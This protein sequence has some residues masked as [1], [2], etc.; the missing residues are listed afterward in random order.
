MGLL[1]E[2]SLDL[3][4]GSPIKPPIPPEG[5]VASVEPL[6]IT[7]MLAKAGPSLEDL[8]KILHNLATFTDSLAE[9]GRGFEENF[10]CKSR[11]IVTKIN[12]GKG[13]LGLLVNDPK[14]YQET[15]ADR[16]RDPE[17]SLARWRRDRGVGHPGQRSQVQGPDAKT[18]ENLAGHHRP[19]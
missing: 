17:S 2:K 12:A 13:S 10:R 16:G 1:G 15:T 18:M 7:Q 9:Q 4:A 11:Q 6:D 3:T 5:M 14:L 19:I 8:Q